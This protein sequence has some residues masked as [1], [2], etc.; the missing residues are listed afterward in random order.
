MLLLTSCSTFKFSNNITPYSQSL[1]GDWQLELINPSDNTHVNNRVRVPNNWANE[2]IEHA[3]EAVYRRQFNI[4]TSHLIISKESISPTTSSTNLHRYWLD[5][6]AVD[7]AATVRINNREVGSHKGY[8]APFSFDI[9]DTVKRGSNQLEV[10]VDSP[11]ETLTQDWSLNKTLIK[12]VLNH[13]DTRP[14]GAWSDRG[15]ERNSGGIWGD[16]ILRKT[17][18]VAIDNIKVTAQ[19]ADVNSQQTEGRVAIVLDSDYQGVITF[20]ITLRP[21]LDNLEQ[22]TK[23]ALSR[24]SN[25]EKY[26]ITAKV[27]KGKQVID[28]QLPRVD[29]ALWWP[30]DWGNPSLYSLTVNVNINDNISDSRQQNIGF[31]KVRF[32]EVEGVFYVNDLP[33]FI[34]GTN[35][36]ASQWLGGVSEDDYANDIALMRQANINSIRVHAHVAGKAF[37]Q[38]ADKLG[39]VVWQ[40]FPLQW[41]YSD[42]PEFRNEAV[43]QAKDMTDM[44]YNHASI[45]FWCG[46]NEPPWDATW[47][48]Y[49][50]P[51]YKSDKNRVLTEAVYQQLS[52]VNDG[53]IVRKASY[54]AEHPWLGW[55]SGKYKDYSNKPKTAI[56]SEFGAQAMPDYAAVID[57]LGEEPEWPLSTKVIE[58]LSYHNYQPRESLQIAKIYEGESLSQ[59]VINSQEYQRLVT[60]YAIEQLRLNKGLGLAA[61]YQFMFNDSWNAITWS[62]LDVERIAKP[63]YVAMQRAYQPLLAILQRNNEGEDSRISVTISNDSLLAYQ[64]VKMMIKD[65]KQGDVWVM[66]NLNIG[67]NTLHQVLR[68]QPLVGLSD[69]VTIVLYDQNDNEISRNEYL[70]QDR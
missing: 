25:I 24:H 20:E 63:G 67:A 46:Q 37:Y 21:N 12:G 52:T 32:D 41:G 39:M 33:Y 17:G 44:L 59:F 58:Q 43:S 42:T 35:Y 31:K 7:Y 56:I 23:E 30:W 28:W 40:D 34:R 47:M 8:F 45:A 53:R 27:I 6:S 29:R 1:N 50:Y 13:H 3:G 15:Q 19:V 70:P 64:H 57:M 66:N 51:S 60:K 4:P 38:Q 22:G 18:L 48:K 49:K 26:Q 5:F 16:V 2:G 69:W 65:N 36:I 55:Y 14:G 11:N 68:K 9:T 62:V 54:T 61:I 10:L